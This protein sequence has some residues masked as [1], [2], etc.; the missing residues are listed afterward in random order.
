M[1]QGLVWLAI[2]KGRAVEA[3]PW[4]LLL[5]YIG[6]SRV[7][8]FHVKTKPFDHIPGT[9]YL[10][11]VD[12]DATLTSSQYSKKIYLCR[13]STA[14]HYQEFDEAVR[15]TPAKASQ[16]WASDIVAFLS[17]AGMLS[18]GAS[19]HIGA[20]HQSQSTES[21]RNDG[22]QTGATLRQAL[23]AASGSSSSKKRLW[24]PREL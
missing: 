6:L 20:Q 22:N 18:N 21:S 2:G 17:H 1:R 4:A 24:R 19:R 16:E 3:R 14:R 11:H 9:K 5:S 13:L 10:L 12:L 15:K 8:R 23:D 7:I